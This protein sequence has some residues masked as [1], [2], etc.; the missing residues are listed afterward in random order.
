MLLLQKAWEKIFITIPHNLGISHTFKSSQLQEHYQR[1]KPVFS[2]NMQRQ[3]TFKR[4]QNS[5]HT[6]LRFQ[7]Q[8][9]GY[10]DE[11]PGNIRVCSTLQLWPL[12]FRVLS[13]ERIDGYQCWVYSVA[14]TTKCLP[15][16][17]QQ[18]KEK[19]GWATFWCAFYRTQKKGQWYAIKRMVIN[20]L[21]HGRT[22]IYPHCGKYTLS[23]S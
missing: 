4:P 10:Q 3:A 13:G 16:T 14:K 9:L 22:L 2:Q 8:I 18:K 12:W 20:A 7:H 19:D 21:I 17:H 5:H 15:H 1:T 11:K 23:F 6:S